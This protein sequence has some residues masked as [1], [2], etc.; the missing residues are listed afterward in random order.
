MSRERKLTDIHT[1]LEQYPEE[2]LEAVLRRAA[3]AGVGWIVTS[4]LDLPTSLQGIQIAARHER[5][6]PSVGVHPWTVESVPADFPEKLEELLGRRGAA[7]VGEVGLDFIDNLFAGTSYRDNPQLCGAQEQ[8]LRRQIALACGA[9]LPLIVHCRGAYPRM[10]A[11]LREE[12][13]SR[14]GGVIHNFDES[15][16]AAG[17]LLDLGFLL[18]F[19]GAVTYPEAASLHDLVRHVPLDGMLLETD[20]PYMPLYRQQAEKN[21]PANVAQVARAIARIKAIDLEELVDRTCKN[22]KRLL[23]LDSSSGPTPGSP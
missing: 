19:G 10:I 9:G 4:G 15:R 13:A 16:E 7:A 1:H 11:I 2:E 8:A 14:V 3:D 22:F 12:E 5:V 21:E 18:S 23:R 6:L 20:S 17:Q